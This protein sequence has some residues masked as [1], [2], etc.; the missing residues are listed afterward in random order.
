MAGVMKFIQWALAI[1]GMVALAIVGV[2]FF[3]P[4]KFEISR[5][6]VI[7]APADKVYDLI[8]D[9]RLW[10]KWTV[11]SR[12]DP[13]MDVTYSG[14]P[15]GQ[16]ARWSWKSASE[17]TGAMEFT[18][19]EPNRRVEYSLF[20]QDFN[21]RSAGA[22]Q[23]DAGPSGTRVTWTS[24]GDVGGNPLKHYLAVMMDRMAGPDFEG[25]LANLKALAEK[26]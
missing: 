9:P 12:R 4:S 10:A 23:L 8:A 7:N 13:K 17:G 1:V 2:G 21:M 11:W 3:L 26:P 6:T 20:F 14:P 15:F 25:G 5:S 22:F 19:V 16:G 24:G 18:R